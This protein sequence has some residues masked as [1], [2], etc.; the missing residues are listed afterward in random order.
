MRLPVQ[1][2]PVQR[3]VSSQPLAHRGAGDAAGAEPGVQPSEYGVVPSFGWNDVFNI[4]KTAAPIAAGL[5]L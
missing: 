3:S 1:S 4:V 2:Q 5:L